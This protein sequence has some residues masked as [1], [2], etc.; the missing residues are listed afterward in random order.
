MRIIDLSTWPRRRHLA[1]FSAFAYPHFNLCV[2]VDITALRALVQQ[3]TV[4]FTIALVYILTRAANG[5]PEFRYRIRGKQVVE[6]DIVHPS[7]IVLTSEEL[8]SFCAIPYTE[9][10]A[11]FAVRAAEEMARAK[12]Q[13]ILEDGPGRDDLLFMTGL[14]WVAFTGLQHPIHRD[15][16]DSV[17]RIAWG[18]F[19]AEGSRVQM[20]LAIQAHHALVDGL[21]VGRYLEQAQDLLDR[22]AQLFSH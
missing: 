22:A 1:F 5:I 20:P 10:F 11:S 12:E 17:P 15:P 18:K 3:R 21:H 6:H 4:P 19:T 13:V 7:I 16:V 8:F 9:D 14:P 2:S